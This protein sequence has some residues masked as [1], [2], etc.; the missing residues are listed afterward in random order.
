MGGEH[1][2]IGNDTFITLH[3]KY[4]KENKIIRKYIEKQE[5]GHLKGQYSTGQHEH[6]AAAA[7]NIPHLPAKPFQT[8]ST[9]S[10]SQNQEQDT[11]QHRA[12]ETEHDMTF[13]VTS[14]C[15]PWGPAAALQN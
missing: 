10:G 13:S 15:T 2:E 5:L 8:L 9:E 12:I 1:T 7:M 4:W 3:D 6:T 11:Y 14:Q